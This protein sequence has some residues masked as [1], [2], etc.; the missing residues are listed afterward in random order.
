M[1][2]FCTALFASLMLAA[3]SAPAWA[4]GAFDKKK[5]PMKKPAPHDCRHHKM[6]KQAYKVLKQFEHLKK[7]YNVTIEDARQMFLE[8]LGSG[9]PCTDADA[10]AVR[11]EY[12]QQIAQLNETVAAR[13]QQLTELNTTVAGQQQ[14]IADLNA[15][16]ASQQLQL[17]EL[18][19]TIASQQQQLAAQAVSHQQELDALAATKDQQCGK[20]IETA[21]NDGMTA[22]VQTCAASVPA[23]PQQVGSISTGTYYPYALDVD[24]NGNTYIVERNYRSVVGYD[25]TGSQIT[26]WTSGALSMPV[27]LAMDSQ[28]NIFILD[29]GAEDFLQKY[30]PSGQRLEFVTGS[31][32]VVF[33]LGLFIDSQDNV[34]VTDMGGAYGGRI[35]KF[36]STGALAATFGEVSDDALFGDEYCD[37]TVDEANQNIY[38][39]THYN[40]MVAKFS[41]DGTYLGAWEGE[42]RNPNSI[43]VGPQGQIFVA[44][45]YNSQVDQYDTDGNLT[46]TISSSQ[47][48]RPYHIVVDNTGKLHIAVEN[49]QSVLVY[50]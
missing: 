33:P 37:I 12:E 11:E 39:V 45:T 25:S 26:A 30:S 44:D 9:Q 32:D 17:V 29:Q 41:M 23:E 22:G 42:L 4:H 2:K 48:Y 14:Q 13:E 16:L 8:F 40:H 49:Y 19:A 31:A 7:T 27:D 47:L 46:Y 3:F 6:D 18:N 28:G 24:G 5:C 35:L 20:K 10:A 38:V 50:E 36:D 43:A 34:Y 15:T 21:Y 1:K